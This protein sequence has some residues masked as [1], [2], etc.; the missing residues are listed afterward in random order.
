MFIMPIKKNIF[1]INLLSV[2][3]NLKK[4]KI[5]INYNNV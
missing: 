5:V 3:T 1:D 4:K 2:D